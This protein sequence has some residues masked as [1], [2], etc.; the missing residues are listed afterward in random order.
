MSI[1]SAGTTTTTALSST[2]NTDGTLQLQV[3]GTTPSVT[4]NTLGAIGVGSSPSYG[5][6]GQVLTSAGSTATPSWSTNVSS[7]WTTSGSDI[8]YNTGFVSIG[9]TA[10]ATVNAVL[11]VY[12]P[13]LSSSQIYLQNTGT[14]TGSTNGFRVLMGTTD[15]TMTNK[16]NGPIIFETNDTERARIPSTGGI[17]SVN[18]I[19]VGNATP[20]T[21]GAGITFPA[22]QSAST[23]ANTLDDYEE[24]SWTPVI[25]DGTNNATMN[26][27]NQGRYTKIGNVVTLNMYVITDSLGSV[28]GNIRI[29]GLPFAC[30][31]G[32]YSG[33]ACG[34]GGELNITANQV[35]SSYLPPATSYI[36][37]FVWNAAGGTT[38]MTSTQWSADGSVIFSLSYRTS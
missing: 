19:S 9:T 1:I 30:V 8:Y 18:S 21:S 33:T 28:S 5:T 38:N 25:S 32:S 35:V 31:S 14:G 36:L 3:N 11:T 37:L 16:E 7:Q 29:T 6:S 13:N 17:Q 22:T 15:V 2:G 27:Q 20:T 34:A 12:N 10:P 23:D 4:L 24:G 26:F